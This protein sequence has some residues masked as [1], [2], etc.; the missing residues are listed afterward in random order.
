MTSKEEIKTY[1][2]N[3][4]NYKFKKYIKLGM[5]ARYDDGRWT[6]HIDNIDDF[7]KAYTK[8]SMKNAPDEILCRDD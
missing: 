2:G 1:I 5:P 6:A 3:V 8:V 4:S 7:F